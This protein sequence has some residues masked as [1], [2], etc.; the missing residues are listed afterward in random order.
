M[1][2]LFPPAHPF[3]TRRRRISLCAAKF[4]LPQADFTVPQDDFIGTPSGRA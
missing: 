2:F 1:S 4:H 3:K